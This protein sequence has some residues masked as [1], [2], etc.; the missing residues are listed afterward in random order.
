VDRALEQVGL[1][2]IQ[3]DVIGSALTGGISQEARKKV[4]IAVELISEPKILFLD[5]PSQC[6]ERCT[7]EHDACQQLMNADSSLSSPLAATGLDSAAATDV[8]KCVVALSRSMSVL[9]TIHQPS[10]EL[11]GMF[12]HMCLLRSGGQTVYFGP[13]KPMPAYFEALG[14]YVCTR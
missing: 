9:C 12:N 8:M 2:R 4:T 6:E 14:P 10:R 7:C 5:E 3:N 13:M 11:I 1:L